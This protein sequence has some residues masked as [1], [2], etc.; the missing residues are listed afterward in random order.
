[1]RIVQNLQPDLIFCDLVMP[2]VDGFELMDCLK[3]NPRLCRVPVIA[4]SALGTVADVERTL[5]AGFAGHLLKPVDYG[6]IE[7][8]LRR[9][10]ARR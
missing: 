4:V 3:R 6:I 2:F 8:Q 1:M 10:F 7:A 5:A 9:V